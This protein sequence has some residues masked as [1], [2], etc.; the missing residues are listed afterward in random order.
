MPP[1]VDMRKVLEV[2]KYSQPHYRRV[3]QSAPP[4]RIWLLKSERPGDL[5]QRC[6]RA[7]KKAIALGLGYVDEALRELRPTAAGIALLPKEEGS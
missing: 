3:K 2:L 5:G 7:V 6:D 1:E 4:G